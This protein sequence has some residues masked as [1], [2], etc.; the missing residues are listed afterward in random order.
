MLLAL[1][2]VGKCA[3]V[4]IGIFGSIDVRGALPSV[5]LCHASVPL[6]CAGLVHVHDTAGT[7]M[8][9]ATGSILPRT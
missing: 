9:I 6:R 4:R 3:L 1:Y 8:N 2:T 7:T 5:D